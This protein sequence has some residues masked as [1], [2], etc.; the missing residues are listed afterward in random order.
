MASEKIPNEPRASVLR[1]DSK[2]SESSQVSAESQT[3]AEFINDQLQLEADAREALPYAFDTCTKP[4]GALRQILFSCLT[5]NPPPSD[6]SAPYTPAGVCY[7]CSI[8]CHGEHTLVELFNKRN[9]ECDCGTTRL[10]STSPCSLRI[11][12]GT[13]AKGNVHSETPAPTNRYNHNFRNRFCG[14]AKLYDAFQEK[15]TMFQCLGLGTVEE[16][17]CGED[18]WHPSCVVGLGPD[19]QPERPATVSSVKVEDD[20]GVPHGTADETSQATNSENA[21]AVKEENH[22]PDPY[23]EEE[24]GELPPPPGFPD[25]EDFEAFIC[26][27][28][29]ESNPWIKRYAGAEGFLPPVLNRPNISNGESAIKSES[30][31]HD[32]GLSTSLIGEAASQ[33]SVSKKRKASAEGA[34]DDAETSS[35]KK[36]KSETHAEATEDGPESQAPSKTCYLESLPAARSV[37]ISLFLKDGFQTRFC[38]C[39]DCFPKLSKFPQ[40]LEEEQS[41]EPPLSEDG[42]N[43]G[44]GSSAGTASLYDRGER[45][46][47]NVDRVRAI[48]GVMV[49]NHLKEK[50]KD[51]LKPFADN[52]Q[53]VGADDIKKYFEQLRG[54][55][56]AMKA[57]GSQLSGKGDDSNG[58]GD[59]RKEQSGY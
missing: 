55:S 57:A 29:V 4:L 25:E 11:H 2:A 10:P 38:R 31:T 8:S 40:L 22:P 17:G 36:H 54:D 52:G 59:N 9:F 49:Y 50:V 58:D 51:F 24:D 33:A 28:C 7:S 44:G 41:Y 46:L 32:E 30:V 27:K 23:D 6:P 53:A 26:Y 48:E 21:T 5:C 42:D 3:A 14:C 34:E 16:G 1:E 13:G 43:E 45:A 37:P 19:W 20:P 35:P 56:E 39:A 18:W 47:S 15:G 12:S